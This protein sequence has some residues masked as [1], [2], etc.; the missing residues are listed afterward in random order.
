[1]LPTGFANYSTDWFIRKRLPS[2]NWPGKKIARL[3]DLDENQMQLVEQLLCAEGQQSFFEPGHYR[4]TLSQKS[5]FNFEL[6]EQ[7]CHI[8]EAAFPLEDFGKDDGILGSF[9]QQLVDSASEQLESD[10]LFVMPSALN[11]D[12]CDSIIDGLRKIPFRVKATNE[13]VEGFSK[14]NVFRV[15]GNTVWLLNHQD[16]LQLPEVQRLA[17][18]PMLLT[19]I[20][21]Y[22]KFVPIHVKPIAGGRSIIE[23]M[24]RLA[25]S[26]RKC[27]TKTRNSFAS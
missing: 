20:Q 11:T 22:L 9:D 15:N 25:M 5:G 3:P 6:A 24:I 21:N 16:L 14:R 2:S 26:T 18:D 23:S 12:A 19:A 7:T 10:G 1:M 4:E 17:T 13:I 27:F 8:L